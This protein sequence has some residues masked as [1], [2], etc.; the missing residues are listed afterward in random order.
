MLTDRFGGLTAFTR[1]PAEGLWEDDKGSV[2]RDDVIVVEVMS[3]EPDDVWWRTYKVTLAQ[4]F[5]QETI[6]IRQLPC[7]IV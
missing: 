5:G 1:A 2:V 4:R 3:D 6:L 7:R